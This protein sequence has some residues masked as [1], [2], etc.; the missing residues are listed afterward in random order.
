MF[1]LSF[2]KQCAKSL[3]KDDIEQGKKY[4]NRYKKYSLWYAYYCVELYQRFL[5][6]RYKV[7][8]WQMVVQTLRHAN[9]L[10][11]KK[12]KQK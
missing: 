7:F 12:V 8:W 2:I 3:D 6:A 4:A 11:R 9:A 1:T 5:L 10:H